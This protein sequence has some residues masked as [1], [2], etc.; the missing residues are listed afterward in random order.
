MATVCVDIIR[1]S[2]MCSRLIHL[3]PSG[4]F[5]DALDLTTTSVVQ[6]SVTGLPLAQE[7]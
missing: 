5:Q 6:M 1:V 4:R 7:S 3:C 2:K